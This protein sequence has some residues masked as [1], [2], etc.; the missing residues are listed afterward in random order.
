MFWETDRKNGYVKNEKKK[1]LFKSIRRI[2]DLICV[3]G[4]ILFDIC[5]NPE[6]NVS[7]KHTFRE[8]GKPNFG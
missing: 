4:F 1:K 7:N 2:S 6:K 3:L 5:Q 8:V